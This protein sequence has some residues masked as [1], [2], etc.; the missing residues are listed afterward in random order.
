MKVIYMNHA[1]KTG[2][3]TAGN[4]TDPFPPY[5]K[6]KLG[7]RERECQGAKHRSCCSN[8][9]AAYSSIVDLKGI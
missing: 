4:V 7:A 2:Y 9:M 5:I 3:I 6:G 1:F 8:N